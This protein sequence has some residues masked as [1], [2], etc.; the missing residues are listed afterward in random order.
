MDKKKRIKEL[1][2]AIK[3]NQDLYYNKQPEISDEEF[4]ALWDEL[5]NLDPQ[6]E[7]F[8]IVGADAVDGFPKAEHIIPMG[9][10]EKAANPAQFL[11]WAGKMPFDEFIVQYKLDGA[12]L[13]LQYEQGVFS[14]AVTRGNGV[15]GDDI[16][17]NVR[18]MQGVVFELH[19]KK[20]ELI[21]FSGGIR[22]EVIMK[23][24]I[25]KKF[26]SDKANCRNATNGVM[27]RKEGTGCEHLTVICY[28]ALSRTAAESKIPS[29]EFYSNE[30]EKIDW[31]RE[32]GFISVV[33]KT[34]KGANEVIEYR[35]EV[36]DLRKN[37]DYDID[38]LV[39][40]Q[41]KLD[42]A[43]LARARPE[44]QI[45]FKFSLEQ[46]VSTLLDVEWS[47]SGATYTPIAIIEPVQLA[48]TVVK[49][50]S[51]ANP[52]IIK[53]LDLKIGSKVIV[54]KRGEI[55]P[56]IEELVS[57]PPKA[58]EI[59][60][61]KNCS[62][63]DT[64][65]ANEGTRLFC[66]NPNCK[67]LIHHRLEKWVAVLDIRELGK[68]LL[69][70]LFESGELNSV[71]D[72][73]KLQAEKL[74]KM[75]RMGEV[76]A[77]KLINSI[78]SKREISLAQFIA[79]FDIEGIGEVMAQK[80]VDAGYDSLEKIF[81]ATEAELSQVYNFGEILAHNFV[82][83]IK[84]VRNEMQNLVDSGTIK[85]KTNETN[86]QLSGKS[87]CFT[88]ELNTM[89]RADAEVLVKQKGGTTKSSVTK[90]LTY[91][92]TNEPNSGSSKNQKA[93]KLNIKI[94]DEKTFL[95]IVGE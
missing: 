16:T 21:N 13:E 40:K 91:L 22:G 56:K 42:I 58:N 18:K 26:Y 80:L 79:G 87:F 36:M 67:K 27:K 43:D 78:N 74:S 28:D 73:Y 9:S 24:S 57:N 17:A 86:L 30:L 54:T 51:L 46:A 93:Q 44:K 75:E 92:V 25:H 76:S 20:G 31:L 38:G 72:I 83:G 95:E 7:V 23:R 48:G 50:A 11:Q 41:N 29:G 37:L 66:P 4:D 19:N 52:N 47:E 63:C 77:Q 15:V 65:L 2:K 8:K 49:R 6:N 71:S 89:K 62:T 34:C 32:C 39:V 33:H 84:D 82:Q 59:S 64:E 55:I 12:S 94:I 35:N 68:T 1:E 53:A 81:N 45:A 5:K 85:I 60:I 90:D 10:Q 61:P 69:W 14:K 3:Y 70:R 88:G